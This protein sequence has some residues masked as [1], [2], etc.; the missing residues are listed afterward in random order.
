MIAVGI[1][2][3][4]YL[5]SFGLYAVF[6]IIKLLESGDKKLPDTAVADFFHIAFFTVPVIEIAYDADISRLW[7]PYSENNTAHAVFFGKM[8]AEQLICFGILSLME[9]I[10]GNFIFLRHINSHNRYS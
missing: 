8:R 1:G 9:K 7:C 5:S 4:L 6:V 10:K 2:L 3:Q